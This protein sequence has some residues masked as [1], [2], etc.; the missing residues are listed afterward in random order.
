MTRLDKILAP[1]LLR[2]KVPR[3]GALRSA[4]R[5]LES[6]ALASIMSS[7]HRRQHG[8]HG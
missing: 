1:A 7:L 8:K 2:E 4:V 5:T 6:I 3:Q